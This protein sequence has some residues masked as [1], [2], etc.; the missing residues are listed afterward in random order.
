M[1]GRNNPLFCRC[2]KQSASIWPKETEEES[3]FFKIIDDPTIYLVAAAAGDIKY[4]QLVSALKAAAEPANLDANHPAQHFL[5][6]WHETSTMQLDENEEPSIVN[7]HSQSSHNGIS[8]S[9]LTAKELYNWSN[10]KSDITNHLVACSTCTEDLPAQPRQKLTEEKKTKD[11]GSPMEELGV[12]YFDALGASWLIAVD[13]Y[14]GYAWTAKIAKPTTDNTLTK[15]VAWFDKFG[16][17]KR[18]RSDGGLQFHQ[19]FTS[20]CKLHSMSHKLASVY[21]PESIC[22]VEAALKSMKALVIRT[23]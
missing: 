6:K 3:R 7:S 11:M 21:N 16:W 22:L 13:R 14:S 10:M 15:L 19:A 8:K 23:K 20:F 17:P 1:G 5:E 18:I 12:D 9:Y 2:S 4:Q